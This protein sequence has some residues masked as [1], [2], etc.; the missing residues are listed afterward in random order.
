MLTA[1]HFSSEDEGAW[2]ALLVWLS[3]YSLKA[4]DAEITPSFEA[5]FQQVR[6]ELCSLLKAK[7]A[8]LNPEVVKTITPASLKQF[9]KALPTVYKQRETLEAGVRDVLQHP[10]L[11]AALEP[12][13]YDCFPSISV[14]KL[15]EAWQESEENRA[16]IRPLLLTNASYNFLSDES[17][18][19]FLKMKIAM[20]LHHADG[21]AEEELA[22]IKALLDNVTGSSKAKEE[23]LRSFYL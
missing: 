16:S 1:P 5:S 4:D 12:T 2:R 23:A 8:T 9:R 11:H 21:N 15:I 18:D 10:D 22:T 19:P 14:E 17:L 7:S 6:S 13:V 3:Q 20:H